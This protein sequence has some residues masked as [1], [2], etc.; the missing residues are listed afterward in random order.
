MFAEPLIIRELQIHSMTVLY[1]EF[2]LFSYSSF[3]I[4]IESFLLFFSLKNSM[5]SFKSFAH[6]DSYNGEIDL[7]V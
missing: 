6:E 4:I 5:K 7:S 1:E 2:T 3:K